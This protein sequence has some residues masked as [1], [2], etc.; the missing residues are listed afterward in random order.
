MLE[1]RAL[2]VAYIFDIRGLVAYQLVAYEKK[3]YIQT[4]TLRSQIFAVRNF[5]D[6]KFSRSFNF[7]NDLLKFFADT[8]FR[9]FRE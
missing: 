7:A 6:Q 3:V 1:T 5:R 2:K 4:V 9:E 8:Y